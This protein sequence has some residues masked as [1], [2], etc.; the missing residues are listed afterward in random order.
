MQR[1]RH[2]LP[3][4]FHMPRPNMSYLYFLG[5]THNANWLFF[6]TQ[7]YTFVE[8]HYGLLEYVEERLIFI[9]VEGVKIRYLREEVAA[10]KTELGSEEDLFR[11]LVV[12]SRVVIFEGHARYNYYCY[13]QSPINPIG[14]LLS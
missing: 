6:T 1:I 3:R 2:F 14:Y 5:H 7:L 11:V 10:F 12:V 9:L 4:F 13:L 8:T